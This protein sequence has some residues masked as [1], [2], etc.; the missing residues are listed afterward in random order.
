MIELNWSAG[1]S[2]ASRGALLWAGVAQV[3]SAR[4]AAPTEFDQWHDDT[5]VLIRK[6]H[7]LSARIIRK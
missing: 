6:M 1:V 2:R 5:F 3:G 4:V 7:L